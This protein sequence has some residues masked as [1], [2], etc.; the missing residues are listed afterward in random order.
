VPQMFLRLGIKPCENRRRGPS[1]ASSWLASSCLAAADE[2][3]L[4][5]DGFA[6]DWRWRRYYLPNRSLKRAAD[7]WGNSDISM[8]RNEGLEMSTSSHYEVA[9]VQGEYGKH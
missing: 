7:R 6:D 1:Q 2:S 5:N 8:Q 9:G 4:S 3:V